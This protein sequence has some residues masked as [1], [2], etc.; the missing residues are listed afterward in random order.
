MA[1]REVTLA[2]KDYLEPGCPCGLEERI[3]AIPGVHDAQINPVADT[4]RLAY[5]PE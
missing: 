4:V 1:H 3:R 2:L 5:D